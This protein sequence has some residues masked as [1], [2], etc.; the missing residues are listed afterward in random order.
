MMFDGRTGLSSAGL[1]V[2]CALSERSDV[3]VGVQHV[4]N[5]HMAAVPAEITRTQ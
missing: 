4:L 1:P 5:P 3:N 2:G